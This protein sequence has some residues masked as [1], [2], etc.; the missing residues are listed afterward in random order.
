[1]LPSAPT[2]N[3]YRYIHSC[4]YSLLVFT[5]TTQSQRYNAALLASSVTVLTSLVAVSNDTK[6]FLAA[7]PDTGWVCLCGRQG[8]SGCKK[9]KKNKNQKK[10]QH[11]G[12]KRIKLGSVCMRNACNGE[13]ELGDLI[14]KTAG[15]Q[16]QLFCQ[17]LPA[18][19]LIDW[20]KVLV[21]SRLL[22]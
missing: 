2:T 11:L 12:V 22:Q 20:G 1:M 18:P 8:S 16:V 7:K 5:P 4:S 15:M 13:M 14:G 9:R 21:F 10:N 6:F 3:T 17:R 19:G